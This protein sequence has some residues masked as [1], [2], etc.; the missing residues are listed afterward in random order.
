MQKQILLQQHHFMNS[1]MSSWVS[2][3]TNVWYVQLK[4]NTKEHLASGTK[5]RVSLE[6]W[7]SRTFPGWYGHFS[8]DTKSGL[9]Y[10]KSYAR[11]KDIILE[12]NYGKLKFAVAC[13]VVGEEINTAII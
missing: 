8:K 4:S 6:R 13:R 7:G 9:G 1:Q 10:T 12:A 3:Q 11:G 5:M 2:Q